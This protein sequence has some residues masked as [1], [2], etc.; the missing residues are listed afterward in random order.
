MTLL[1]GGIDFGPL[2]PEH[3]E[4]LIAGFVLFV[5]I[6][7]VI[8]KKVVPAFEAT[9]DRR[10]AEITGGI[11]K[12]EAAQAEAAK[13]LADY[14]AQLAD[15]RGEAARIRE[16]AKAQAATTAAE[17]RAH[18]QADADRIVAT[19][20]AQLEAERAQV[21]AKLRGEIGGLATELAGRIVGET[22][23]D[24]DVAKRTVDRFLAELEAQPV[25]QA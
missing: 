4:E 2:L 14:Q 1:E 15:A 20:K 11:E 25:E 3:P 9:Y 16:D 8:M 13:A 17:I 18:A 22:L 6:V 12:A 21:V 23:T 24:A 10:T 7:V 5:I 19:A